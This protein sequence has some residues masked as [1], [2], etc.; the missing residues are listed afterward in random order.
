MDPGG[1][2][3][4]Q[5]RDSFD[6][7]SL[8]PA[9]IEKPLD[10]LLGEHMRQRCLCAELR[11]IASVA[12]VDRDRA[13]VIVEHLT[14][15]QALHHR[16]E[17]HDLFPAVLRRSL[18]EDNLAPIIERLLRDH[19]TSSRLAHEIAAALSAHIGDDERL[20]DQL[21]VLLKS[22]ADAESR[23]LAIENAIVM[24][25][26]RKRLRSADLQLISRRMKRRREVPC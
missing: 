3:G 15:A 18:P 4:S 19:S 5:C 16:D 12:S 23:H 24:V 22:Y 26:A 9:L 10:F 21:C 6:S 13:A 14:R 8:P 2:T 25:I 1:S 20:D 11:H 7:A 17:E